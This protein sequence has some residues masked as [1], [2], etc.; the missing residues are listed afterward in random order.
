MRLDT[1]AKEFRFKHVIIGGGIVGLY[2]ATRLVDTG[3][4]VLLVEKGGKHLSLRLQGTLS[5]S[6]SSDFSHF[7]DVLGAVQP[8]AWF[9]D[10]LFLRILRYSR[11]GG[12]ASYWG[13]EHL[14]LTEKEFQDANLDIVL[15]YQT[16][17][18]RFCEHV[19]PFLTGQIMEQ[20]KF[21]ELAERSWFR[22]LRPT[23]H[24]KNLKKLVRSLEKDHRV[25][26][27]EN[28]T[29]VDICEEKNVIRGLLVDKNGEFFGHIITQNV[30]LCMGGIETTRFLCH[31]TEGKISH[32]GERYSEVLHGQVGTCCVVTK[33]HE[34][35]TE[36]GLTRECWRGTVELGGVSYSYVASTQDNTRWL[37]LLVRN[38]F[39]SVLFG[40][41]MLSA[42][43]IFKYLMPIEEKN[44]NVLWICVQG[45]PDDCGKVVL[46]SDCD[47]FGMKKPRIAFNPSTD[48]TALVD[49]IVKNLCQ[50]NKIKDFRGYEKIFGVERPKMGFL[51]GGAHMTGGT[52]LG[53]KDLNVVDQNLSLVGIEQIKVFSSSIIARAPAANLTATVM[54]LVDHVL[55]KSTEKNDANLGVRRER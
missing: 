12:S 38:I 3:E 30:Y 51:Y 17:K 42:L 31:S 7:E 33:Q 29:L 49:E 40:S 6:S 41:P 4:N 52:P 24:L 54:A 22:T 46:G 14:L 19:F 32:I 45:P 5:E 13:G 36:G 50:N 34:E 37:T 25:A 48:Y 23:A 21:D 9:G 44:R 27:L 26:I 18:S 20:K 53:R 11:F 1:T 15:K 10:R 2:A 28:T 43:K 35:K 47:R 16:Y 8:N 55:S 39:R